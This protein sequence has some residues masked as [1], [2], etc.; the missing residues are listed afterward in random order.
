G[1]K[2]SIESVVFSPDGT[3]IAS[4]SQDKTATLWDAATGRAVRTLRE[5]K[6]TV[7]GVA[8]SPDGRL[9]ATSSWDGDLTFWDVST[10]KAT[11]TFPGLCAIAFSRDGTRIAAGSSVDAQ[12]WGARLDSGGD[13]TRITAG[14]SENALRVLDA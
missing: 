9:I 14:I 10:G 3:L 2:A 1:H 4:G 7:Q 12:E 5:F 11:L 13:Y 8:F 6:G